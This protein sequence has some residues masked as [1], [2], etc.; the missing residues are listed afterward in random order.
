LLKHSIYFSLLIAIVAT[1]PLSSTSNAQ[2][3]KLCPP[4]TSKKAEKFFDEAKAARK[5]KKDFSV[6]RNLVM[7]AVQEDT[8][9]AE[10]WLFLGD[11]ARIR[12]DF[13]TMKSAYTRLIELCP[14]ADE[15]AYYHLGTYLYDTKNYAEAKKYLK[16][17]LEFGSLNEAR[18]KESEMLLFR[19]DMISNPVPFNPVV[20]KGVSTPD[21]EYLAIISPDNEFCYFTRRFDESR[22]GALT[23]MSV[24]KF[25]VAK[26]QPDGEFDKGEPMPLPFNVQATNNEG[27]ATISKDNKVMYFTRNDN[28][29]FDLFYSELHK[30]KWGEITNLGP[31]VNDPK[32]W[33]SQP[34]LSPDG[35][36]LYFASFRDSVYGTCDIFMTKKENGVFTKPVRLPFNTNG[37]EKSPFIHPDNTTLYFSS[38]SLPGMGGFDIFMVKKG[39]D[40]RWGKPVNLGYPI[41]TEADEVGF[42]VSTDG[43][44][45]YY[46]SNKLSG[47][48]GYDIYSFDLP[49][50]K[51]PERVLFV[52]GQ[53]KNEQD[54]IPLAAKIELRNLITSEVIDVEYDTLTGHYASVV[55]FN[56]DYIM[57]VK[58]E[59]YAYQSQY[60]SEEDTTIKGVVS[61]DLEM[62]KMEVGQSYKLNDIL[63]ETNSSALNKGSKNIILDFAAFLKENPKVSVAIHGHTDSEG[64]PASNMKLSS[65]RAKAVYDFL[66]TTGISAGRLSH[67]GF[68]QTKPVASND[69]AEG[70]SKNRRTEFLIVG[71]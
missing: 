12:N 23:P 6:I 57:T 10:P 65:E 14:D 30:G 2:G 61:N 4:P 3:L 22:R 7:K 69:D 59:G 19:A 11:V 55:L 13:R 51:R 46:A 25:M 34:S 17:F 24:E 28:G 62:L 5:A 49:E 37:N 54:E 40:G 33:D 39:D 20:V 18:N 15:S 16:S 68:G 70:R 45:G 47:S 38:D 66:I 64:D 63:F 67:K 9:W 42:F 29:N 52:K 43:E 35:K 44:K 27:G 71:K 8:S 60:F 53:L 32:Q 56:S 1:F 31:A 21:P 26:R 50:S 41:N 48:G 36:V 58:K